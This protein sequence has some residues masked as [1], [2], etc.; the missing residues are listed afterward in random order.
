M[1]KWMSPETEDSASNMIGVKR[2]PKCKTI[3]TTCVRYGNIL[4]KHFNDVM[5]IRKKIFGNNQSQKEAQHI[6]ANKIQRQSN[7]KCEFE[8]IREFLERKLFV[9]R[10]IK[11]KYG[12]N[13]EL[14]LL[15]VSVLLILRF[16]KSF[17]IIE[18]LHE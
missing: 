2:C 14:H 17:N 3:I 9:M 16:P 7:Q 13:I 6:I 12:L 18:F 8:Y 11:T 5:R 10:Q 15:D 1:D 4:K